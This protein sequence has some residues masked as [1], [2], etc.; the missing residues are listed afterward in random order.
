MHKFPFDGQVAVCTCCFRKK[1]KYAAFFNAIYWNVNYTRVK[2][3]LA[4]LFKKKNDFGSY[5]L[6]PVGTSL[7]YFHISAFGI[8]MYGFF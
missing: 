5:H 8:C 6:I 4:A 1:K 3:I 7:V 2:L